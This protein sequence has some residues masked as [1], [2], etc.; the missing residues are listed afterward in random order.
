MIL[1]RRDS[2]RTLLNPLHVEFYLSAD[3]QGYSN[4]SRKFPL[5]GNPIPHALSEVPACLSQDSSSTYLQGKSLSHT[6]VY[7]LSYNCSWLS[8]QTVTPGS[9]ESQGALGPQEAGVSCLQACQS[10][11]RPPH[12]HYCNSESISEA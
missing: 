5:S 7:T 1:S 12:S 11:N 6:Y 3:S 4:C 2:L 9:K 10:L 8:H